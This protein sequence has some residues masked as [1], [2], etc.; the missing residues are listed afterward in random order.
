MDNNKQYNSTT[1]DIVTGEQKELIKSSKY[2]Q[3]SVLH[4]LQYAEELCKET[5]VGS[6]NVT[7]NYYSG[8]KY[9]DSNRIYI[10]P[11]KNLATMTSAMERNKEEYEQLSQQKDLR[12]EELSK[13]KDQ[14]AN[15][16]TQMQAAA[17]ER[18]SSLTSEKQRYN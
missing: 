15:A 8:L 16:L 11:K 17:N 7:P 2:D 18:E 6:F 4:K 12:I 5:E 1:Y 10:P 14:Q 9:I 3:D 13:A